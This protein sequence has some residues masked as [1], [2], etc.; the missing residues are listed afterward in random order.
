METDLFHIIDTAT[1]HAAQQ[2]PRYAPSSFA[3]EGF[4]HLSLRDQIL[5]PANLLYHGRDDLL[6]LVIDAGKVDAPVVMEPGSHGEDELFP[7]MYGELNLDSVDR[8]VDFPCADDGSFSL[9]L[10]L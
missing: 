3:T 10:G 9:P 7:H 5:R 8:V 6:L 2:H 1:W 4:I